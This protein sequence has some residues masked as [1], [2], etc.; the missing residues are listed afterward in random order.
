MSFVHS[1]N[2]HIFPH[3]FCR[4]RRGLSVLPGVMDNQD[5]QDSQ[6]LQG[7]LDL[8][9]RMETRYSTQNMTYRADV[10]VPTDLI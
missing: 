8:Q 3:L 4:E 5:R 6:G 7:L 10:N 2:I 1:L 9:E